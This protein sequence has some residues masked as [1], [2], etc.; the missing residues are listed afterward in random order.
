M[1]GNARPELGIEIL[2]KRFSADKVIVRQI[3]RGTGL[4]E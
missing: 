1:C 4:D 3:K 2:K